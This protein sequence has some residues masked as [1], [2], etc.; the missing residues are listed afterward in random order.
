M[1]A[2]PSRHNPAG[3]YGYAYNSHIPWQQIRPS[4]TT[5]LRVSPANTPALSSSPNHWTANTPPL[6]ALSATPPNLSLLPPAKTSATPPFAAHPTGFVCDAAT[7]HQ[8]HVYQQQPVL[9]GNQEPQHRQQTLAPLTSLDLLHCSPFQQSASLFSSLSV[10]GGGIADPSAA[11]SGMMRS[12]NLRQSLWNASITSSLGMTTDHGGQNDPGDDC[13]DMPFAVEDW[14]THGAKASPNLTG[15][16]TLAVA[17]FVQKCSTANHRLEMFDQ[18]QRDADDVANLADQLADFKNFGASLLIEGNS[19][20]N[21]ED[22]SS[23]RFQ[24][25]QPQQQSQ[26]TMQ[27]RSS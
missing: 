27:L 8:H 19:A 5:P 12:E 20:A 23:Y 18:S 7:S 2:S 25:Q 26:R 10:G 14:D 21:G 13:D 9:P 11:A 17:S 3:E 6:G 1:S 15:S 22:I 4:N 16:S 24:Q